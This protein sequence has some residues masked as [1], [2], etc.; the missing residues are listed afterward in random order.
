MTTFK[1][2]W[3]AK[4]PVF[5]KKVIKIG[6]GIAAVGTTIITLPV[7]LPAVLVTAGSYM[8]AVGTTAATIAKLTKI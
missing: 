3:N 4:T 2:R 8:V 5:F 1:R 7:A 6:L